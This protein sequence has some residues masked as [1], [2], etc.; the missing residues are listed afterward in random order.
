MGG[1]SPPPAQSPAGKTPVLAANVAERYF[2]LQE[3]PRPAL[4]GEFYSLSLRTRQAWTVVCS[5]LGL[6]WLRPI[7][8]APMAPYECWSGVGAGAP[9]SLRGCWW[10][11][12]MVRFHAISRSAEAP[13]APIDGASGARA[14]PVSVPELRSLHRDGRGYRQRDDR[15]SCGTRHMRQYF[16]CNPMRAHVPVDRRETSGQKL[17][18]KG[19]SDS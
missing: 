8:N 13:E 12:Q 15:G 6:G 3:R 2:D 10:L 14:A 7:E 18:G 4:A 5:D 9:L 1:E 19:W 17:E 16:V 11:V